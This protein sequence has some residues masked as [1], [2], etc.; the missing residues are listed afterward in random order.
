RAMIQPM[1]H[2]T[3]WKV[4]PNLWGA[5]IA[6]PGYMKTPAIKRILRPL[7]TIETGWHEEFEK[8]LNEYAD[9]KEKSELRHAAWRDKFKAAV[10]DGSTEPDSPKEEIAPEKPTQK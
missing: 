3:T 4:I 5:G 8:E 10:K 9:S 2:D 6:P 7:A 1:L